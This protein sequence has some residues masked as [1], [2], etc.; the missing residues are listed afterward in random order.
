MATVGLSSVPRPSSGRMFK[1]PRMPRQS[2][3]LWLGQ[4]VP[5]DGKESKFLPTPPPLY[6]SSS[7][8]PGLR[9]HASA[10][11]N[12]IKTVEIG[13]KNEEERRRGRKKERK[14]RRKRGQRKGRWMVR[15]M[16]GRKQRKEKER[17]WRQRNK[18]RR[19]ENQGPTS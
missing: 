6:A 2:F 14:G 19:E 9:N 7:S 4:Q 5:L 12:F 10:S 3:L 13:K 1:R 18:G 8:K 16:E 11:N 17:G 15:W